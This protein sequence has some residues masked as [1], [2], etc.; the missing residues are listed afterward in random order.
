MDAEGIDLTLNLDLIF[1]SM[2]SALLWIQQ[3]LVSVSRISD[4]NLEFRFRFDFGGYAPLI[5]NC[6]S[7]RSFDWEAEF[8]CG[9]NLG[10]RRRMELFMRTVIGPKEDA[11][12][13]SIQRLR[14]NGALVA[15]SV[16]NV[17]A[18]I[19]SIPMLNGTNFKVWKETV[20]IV[21]GCMDLDLAL[22]V[23][24]PIPTMDNL[25]EVK[26]EKWERSNRMCLMIMKRSIPEAFRGSISESQ[27]A[28]KFLEEIEQFFAK[29]E[30]AETSNLLAKLI[31]M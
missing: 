23:E 22:R 13:L 5:R 10:R 2:A 12:I 11:L 25:Q 30:K 24:E 26:I 29:N 17:P 21:L 15:A 31:T 3:I 19:N 20:E 1:R 4:F 9:F 27:N 16:I 14:I 6:C 7:Q 18:Q 28:I 8:N